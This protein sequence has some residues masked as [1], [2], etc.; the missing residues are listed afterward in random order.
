MKQRIFFFKKKHILK[1]LNDLAHVKIKYCLNKDLENLENLQLFWPEVTSVRD[2][3]ITVVLER[4][5]SSN[6][7]TSLIRGHFI[8]EQ[9]DQ[10]EFLSEMV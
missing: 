6:K 3:L 4:L 8:L 1:E 10:K 7:V 9:S 5:L 2:G